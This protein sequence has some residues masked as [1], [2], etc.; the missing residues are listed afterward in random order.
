MPFCLTFKGQF[1]PGIEL[2]SATKYLGPVLDLHWLW[3]QCST[4][5]RIPAR[6]S[7]CPARPVLTAW[8]WVWAVCPLPRHGLPLGFWAARAVWRMPA[9]PVICPTGPTCKTWQVRF[10]LLSLD[11]GRRYTAFCFGCQQPNIESSP[12]HTEQP[13]WSGTI[14]IHFCAIIFSGTC[15]GCR[16]RQKKCRCFG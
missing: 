14:C 9:S 4:R 7:G 10:I 15:A 5:E 2:F 3:L 13:L 16:G 6:G 11:K 1:L 12:Q 8:G